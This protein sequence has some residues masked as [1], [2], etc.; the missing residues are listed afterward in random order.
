MRMHKNIHILPIVTFQNLSK[1]NSQECTGNFSRR[2]TLKLKSVPG[3]L[4][5]A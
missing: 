3:E 4:T 2:V 1:K 5:S